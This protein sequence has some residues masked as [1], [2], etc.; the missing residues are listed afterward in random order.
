MRKQGAILALQNGAKT[1]KNRC[2]YASWNAIFSAQEA[3]R[4][5]SAADRRSGWS[6]PEAPGGG[7]RRGKTR[8]R[9]PEPL[10]QELGPRRWAWK[11]KKTWID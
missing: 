6:P 5:A 10:R 1:L 9:L 8:D 4:R 7:F 11:D 3:P 2:W